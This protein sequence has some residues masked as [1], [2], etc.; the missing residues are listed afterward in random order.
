V[1]DTPRGVDLFR[2]ACAMDLEGI[3][4][5]L[6]TGTYD[7]DNPTWRK[8]RKPRYSQLEGRREFFDGRR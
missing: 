4:A 1:L 6:A 8:I 3:V 7:P 5:K 2:S